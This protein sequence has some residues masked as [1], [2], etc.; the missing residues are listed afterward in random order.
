MSA[1]EH[2]LRRSR[3]RSIV[4]LALL[5]AVSATPVRAQWVPPPPPPPDPVTGDLLPAAPSPAPPGATAPA[6]PPA[7]AILVP[8]R[9]GRMWGFANEAGGMVVGAAYR[10]VDLAV[11]RSGR[12]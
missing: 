3:M 1:R 12:L 5:L 2:I 9:A 8:Y 7:T 10:D 6:P 4:P 11:V